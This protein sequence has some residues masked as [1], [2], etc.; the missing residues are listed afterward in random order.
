MDESIKSMHLQQELE[1]Y[2]RETVTLRAELEDAR[3]AP[4]PIQ[5]GAVDALV[6]D[7]PEGPRIYTLEGAEQVYRNLIESMQ[8]GAVTLNAEGAIDYCNR[9]FAELLKLPLERIIGHRLEEWVDAANYPAM[10]ALLAEGAD[11][12]ELLFDSADGTKT[13]TLVSI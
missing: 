10:T 6:I 13:P 2:R 12:R 8:D 9:R 4:P 1:A 3:D 11:R 5:S 7:A